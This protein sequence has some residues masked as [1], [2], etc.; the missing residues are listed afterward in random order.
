MPVNEDRALANSEE[1]SGPWGL[2]PAINDRVAETITRKVMSRLSWG[3]RQVG[4]RLHA[5]SSPSTPGN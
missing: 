1:V 3:L 5:P 4:A 2:A